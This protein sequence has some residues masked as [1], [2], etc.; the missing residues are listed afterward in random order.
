MNQSTIDTLYKTITTTWD[1]LLA[2]AVVLAGIYALWIV[3]SAIIK[4]GIK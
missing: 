1:N 4:W 2:F 3:F